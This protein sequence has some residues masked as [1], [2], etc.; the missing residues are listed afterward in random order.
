MLSGD[1]GKV[2][3]IFEP[4]NGQT[5]HIMIVK[6]AKYVYKRWRIYA[7]VAQWLRQRHLRYLLSRCMFIAST[8]HHSASVFGVDA[9]HRL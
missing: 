5:E 1:R 6:E 2:Y 4:R 9:G 7:G 8:S 3:S